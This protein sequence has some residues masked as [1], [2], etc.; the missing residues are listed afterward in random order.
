MPKILLV[1]QLSPQIGIGH[2][3]RL[4]SIAEE[5]RNKEEI[6]PEF[7][8]FGKLIKNN[9][10][11]KFKVF[12]TAMNTPLNAKVEELAALEQYKAI[13][14][15]LHPSLISEEINELFLKLK[16]KNIALIA[17][18]SLQEYCQNLDVV[19][20]P[21]ISFDTTPYIDCSCYMK[22]GWDSLLIKKRLEPKKWASGNRVLILT[23]GSDVSGVGQTLPTLL[24]KQ[25][26][27]NS[28]IN[29]VKGPFAAMPRIPLN[30]KL[31]WL[32]HD[33]PEHLDHL[34]LKSNYVMTVFGV[35]FFEVLQYGKPSV[36]FSP[37]NGKDEETLR[38]LQ[39]ENVSFVAENISKGVAGLVRIMK[40]D[41]MASN[42]SKTSLKKM[43]ING[44]IGLSKKIHS[45]IN[46]N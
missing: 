6:T 38:R 29:W 4:L 21:S 20:I 46:I 18:D 12:N 3:T 33:A 14:F 8:I 2:L 1:C 40:D 17:I 19:W 34:I 22:S 23:G 25:L 26:D 45:L 15:D 32:V 43:S 42:Y 9:I 16:Q 5:L 30:K 35:S 7:L 28:E 27:I 11:N 39:E 31:K 24:D 10:L 44:S 13:V 37:Y 36:V 41:E